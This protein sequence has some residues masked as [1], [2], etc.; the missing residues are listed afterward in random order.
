M[1]LFDNVMF[2]SAYMKA[3]ND[4]NTHMLRI[5]REDVVLFTCLEKEFDNLWEQSSVLGSIIDGRV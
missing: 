4:L 2:I 3:K 1:L 5:T